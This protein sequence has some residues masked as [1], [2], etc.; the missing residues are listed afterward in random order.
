MRMK[1]AYFYKEKQKRK[2][3]D[4][5]R[6]LCKFTLSMSTHHRHRKID[7]QFWKQFEDWWNLP[8]VVD[9]LDG[10]HMRIRS[11]NN[12]GTLFYN[13]KNCFSMVLLFVCDA[14]Y[15]FTVFHMGQY[16]SNNNSGVLL[17]SKMGKNLR[18]ARQTFLVELLSMDAH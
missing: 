17:N 13:Y 7:L 11:P 12:T 3:T 18:R 1:S 5:K 2:K 9:A 10:K 16:G 14:K 4:E 6:I 15:C 8:H